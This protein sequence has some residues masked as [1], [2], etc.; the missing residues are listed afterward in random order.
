M[1]VAIE[2]TFMAALAERAPGL[3][4][5]GVLAGRGLL[6]WGYEKFTSRCSGL[7]LLRHD[8]SRGHPDQDH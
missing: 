3:K 5:A 4:R 1:T 8:G 7:K 2:L 6:V